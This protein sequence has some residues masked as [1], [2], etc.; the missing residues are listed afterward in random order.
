MK[1]LEV[2]TTEV[3]NWIKERHYLKSTPACAKLRL[4]VTDDTGKIIGAMMWGRPTTQVLDNGTV[5]ELTRMYFV[6]DT[7][8][9]TE[10]KA[11]AKARKRIRKHCPEI[12]GVL[13]YASTG[14]DHDGVVYKADNWFYMGKTKGCKWSTRNGKRRKNIDISDKLRWVRSV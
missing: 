13:A 9:C 6:D 5:L 12:R 14:Q 3:D 7:E 2:H 10:S 11:L 8:H 1:I 4:W